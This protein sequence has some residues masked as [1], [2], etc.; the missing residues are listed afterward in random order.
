MPNPKTG[1][2]DGISSVY[3][4]KLASAYVVDP[5]A[6]M[7]VPKL[8]REE[9]RKAVFEAIK[10]S[11]IRG[12][13]TRVPQPVPPGTTE[14]G[15]GITEGLLTDLPSKDFFLKTLYRQHYP[16]EDADGYP[17]W[18]Q[19]YRR[20]PEGGT[21][22]PKPQPQQQPPAKPQQQVNESGPAPGRKTALN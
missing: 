17:P 22:K 2:Y 20:H 16:G 15:A 7:E 21:A 14:F 9:E 13:E 5:D 11:T 8:V 3:R 4:I 18:M 6:P 10:A 1:K 19:E 12:A